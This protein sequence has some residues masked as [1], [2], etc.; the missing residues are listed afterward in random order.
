MELRHLRYFAAVAETLSFSRAAVRLRIAQPSLSTQIR[1]LES[2][3]GFRLLDREHNRVALTDAGVVFRREALQILNKVENAVKKSRAAADGY[4][5]ELRVASMGPLTFSFMPLCLGKFRAAMPGVRVTVTETAPSEQLS[6]IAKGDLHVG[7]VPAPFPKLAGARHLRAEKVLKSPLVVMLAPSH[8]LVRGKFVRLTDCASE[9]F[10]HIRMFETDSQRLWTQDICRKAGFTPRFGAA[11]LN[12]DNLISMVAA[13]E[14]IALIPKVAQRG[15]APGC[16]YM[17]IAEKKLFYE[18]LAVS[19][20]QV[21]SKLVDHFLEIV[22]AE[23]GVVEE[24]LYEED[25]M[26]ESP[27]V[28]KGATVKTKRAKR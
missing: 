8:P 17:P 11:A 13:G 15:P 3:L 4:T 22:S 9:T 6:K 2:E 25:G 23:A 7:F 10:L 28:K 12:P 5:G 18:L 26:S 16:L 14:G 21:P 20:P 19:N 1:D 24:R 27:Q